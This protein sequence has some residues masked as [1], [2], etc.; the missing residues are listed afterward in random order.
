M[1]AA[2]VLALLAETTVAVSV[3]VVLVLLLRRPLREAFGAA[4]AYGA[5]LLVPAAI[6]A[7]LLPAAAATPAPASMM[8]TLGNAP[9]QTLATQAVAAIDTPWWLVALWCLGAVAMT[10]RLA[11]Q[12]R[13]FR[14]A[15]GRLHP[16]GDGLRQADAITG[17][18]AALGLWRPVIV[19]PADFEARYSDEQRRL[20][21]LHE[22]THIVRGDLHLNAVVAAMRCL[23]WFNPLLHYAARHFRHDQE[24]ACD[25]RVIARHPHARRA[26]GEAMFKTQLAAQPL[27]L[28]CHWGYSH[29]L[30]ERIAMLKQPLPSSAR[31]LGGSALVLALSLGIGFAAWS[32]QPK[33][34]V[35]DAALI[36]AGQVRAQMAVRLDGGETDHMTVLNKLGEPFV[37]RGENEERQWEVT[38]TARQHGVG[39]IALDSTVSR[40]GKVV[41][42]PKLV[43]RDGQ[44]AEISIGEINHATGGFKGINIKVTLATAAAAAAPVAAAARS[45]AASARAASAVAPA[46][47]PAARLARLAPPTYP[48]GAS[49]QGSVIL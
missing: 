12:Q 13:G 34:L 23:F 38:A 3:A 46:P 37:V 44:T 2:D 29:P 10:A 35:T 33:S 41:A 19:V 17:L 6:L 28:G 11:M 8:M 22:R 36:P 18:P 32:A 7:V 21:Q 15:L 25:Q 26:Y 9:A 42:T 48:D 5:W 1:N 16:R 45:A 43:V 27:P 31:W 4:V 40:D 20:M 14:R 24:L 39:Q 47:A 49:L 30:T